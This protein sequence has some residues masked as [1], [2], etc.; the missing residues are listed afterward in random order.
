MVGTFVSA[1]SNETH[2]RAQTD[3][4]WLCF[5]QVTVVLTDEANKI[6]ASK[7]SKWAAKRAFQANLQ[8]AVRALMPC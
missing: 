8:E 7:K 4:N 5:L 2:S 6:I 1:H 3:P